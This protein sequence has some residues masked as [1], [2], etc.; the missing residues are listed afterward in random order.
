MVDGAIARNQEESTRKLDR[1]LIESAQGKRE[2]VVSGQAQAQYFTNRDG[3]INLNLD[4]LPV[5]GRLQIRS[6]EKSEQR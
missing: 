2:K 5:S 1:H 6:E 3:S 4:A